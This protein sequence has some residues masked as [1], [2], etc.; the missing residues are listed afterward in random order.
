MK[1]LAQKQFDKFIKHQKND[2]AS[3]RIKRNRELTKI[4][5]GSVIQNGGNRRVLASRG[6]GE[7]E[8][9]CLKEMVKLDQEI[10]KVQKEFKE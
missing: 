2:V 3:E 4:I 5:T 10:G 9:L 8:L 7:K 1:E 6:D